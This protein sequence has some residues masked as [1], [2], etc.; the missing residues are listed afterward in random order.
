MNR[1]LRWL[2]VVAALL[3]IGACVVYE[4]VVVSPQSTVQQRFDRA[5]AAA[6]G[7]MYDQG[8][9]ITV[10][11]R[12]TGVIRGE[13]GGITITATFQT[14]ADSSIQVRFNSSGANSTDPTLI[15]RISDS[16]DRRMGM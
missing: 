15:N 8:V 2:V 5:W 12:A 9:A 3:S 13:R 11:D 1:R 10:Q 14:M 7:A 4:P 6:S 16:Y